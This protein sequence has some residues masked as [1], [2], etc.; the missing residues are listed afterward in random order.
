MW[1]LA[2]WLQEAEEG[3]GVCARLASVW[4]RLEGSPCSVAYSS[5][6]L[7]HTDP[8]LLEGALG[9]GEAFFTPEARVGH[10]CDSFPGTLPSTLYVAPAF[11]LGA[12]KSI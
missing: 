10:R 12:T 5:N 1:P 8:G 11:S 3:R 2:A 4:P 6:Q 9:L 7:I